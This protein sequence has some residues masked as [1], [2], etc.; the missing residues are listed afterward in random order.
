[1]TMGGDGSLGCFIDDISEDQE[2][3]E[4]IGKIVFVPLP[5]GTGNDLS[6]SLGWG[7]KEGPWG[8]DLETLS[9]YMVNAPQDM[10]TVWDVHVYAK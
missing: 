4:N 6:R 2:I 5:Y 9:R 8:R 3:A 7:F 1:M 10:F